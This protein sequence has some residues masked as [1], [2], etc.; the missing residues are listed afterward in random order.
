MKSIS[1]LHTLQYNNKDEV[2]SSE[3]QNHAAVGAALGDD[4]MGGDDLALSFSQQDDSLTM[5]IYAVAADFNYPANKYF[6]A[7]DVSRNVDI[8]TLANK[9]ESQGFVCTKEE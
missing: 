5:S 7:R 9:Y 2:K 4:G 1:L 6:L 8:D 3:A